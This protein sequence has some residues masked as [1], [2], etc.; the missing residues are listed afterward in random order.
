MEIM[1]NH[2]RPEFLGRLTEIIPFAPISESIVLM[3]FDI[4]MKSLYK[5]L[6]LQGIKLEID[7]DAKKK[8]AMSGFNP[9]YGA[10]PLLGIIRNQ[11]RRPLS[12]K[13]IAGEIS[14]GSTVKISLDKSGEI[15][16]KVPERN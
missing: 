10:R 1:S 16:W 11:L 2:F 5:L 12:R 15:S 6:D 3:I 4:H 13:I 14:R 8:L 7:Q 9:K